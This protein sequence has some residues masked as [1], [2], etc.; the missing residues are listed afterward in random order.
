M[1][2]YQTQ[3]STLK[4]KLEDYND[5]KKQLKLMEERSADY[6]QLNAQFEED[7]KKCVTLKGQVERYKVEVRN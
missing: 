2:V 4:A 5:L 6:N 1:K 7:V 3:V